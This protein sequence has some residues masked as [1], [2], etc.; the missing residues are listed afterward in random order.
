[1]DATG[2][3]YFYLSYAKVP[4]TLPQPSASS[5][6]LI[7]TFF[8]DLSASVGRLAHGRSRPVGFYDP[9]AGDSASASGLSQAEVMVQ[10][11]SDRYLQSP[12]TAWERRAFTQRM[13]EAHADPA[14]RIKPVYWMP[15]DDADRF[16][17]RGVDDDVPYYKELGLGALCEVGRLDRTQSVPEWRDAYHKI[18][19]RV[20]GRIV[21]TAERTPIG[22]SEVPEVPEDAITSPAS[23][24]ILIAVHQA[25]SIAPD[26]WAPFSGSLHESIARSALTVAQ[27]LDLRAAVV[28]MPSAVR[29]WQRKPTVLLIDAWLADDPRRAESLSGTLRA[30]PRWV[31]PLVIADRDD[32][33]NVAR[34]AELRKRVLDML[35]SGRAATALNVADHDAGLREILPVLLTQARSRYLHE[36]PRRYPKRPRLGTAAPRREPAKDEE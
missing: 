29:L 18:V 22:P 27:R 26:E 20:A 3:L 10:L 25:G 35:G 5:D 12:W 7:D 8:S 14:D 21:T 19:D 32:R 31:V 1:M 30:L 33:R 6:R 16:G 15:V 9:A 28:T 36:M 24:A 23:A 11:C 2:R 17:L 34:V 13:R 4:P